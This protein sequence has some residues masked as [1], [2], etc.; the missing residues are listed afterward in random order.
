MQKPSVLFSAYLRQYCLD[1][2]V[3]GI[4]LSFLHFFNANN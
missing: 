2:V 3:K 4:C 1:Q